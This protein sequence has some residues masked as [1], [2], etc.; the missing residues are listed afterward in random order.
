MLQMTAAHWH[1]ITA[2]LEAQLPNEACGLLG[3][4][5]GVVEHVYL[6]E[7]SLHSPVRYQMEPL[8]QIQA[9]MAIDDAGLELTA[10]FHSH[11]RGPAIP[12]P[13]DV[14]EAY[15][16]ETLYVIVS[17]NERNQWHSRAF[18]IQNGQVSE[19]EMRV[20]PNL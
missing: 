13:T 16:P 15:Y 5:G 4:R 2:H 1:V 20:T 3:G 8:A 11:P 7:N 6:V 18:Y 10:I 19:V 12:S 17:P 9:M 14:A